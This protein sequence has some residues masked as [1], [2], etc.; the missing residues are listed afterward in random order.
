MQSA[1]VYPSPPPLVDDDSNEDD[2]TTNAN[3]ND[4][5]NNV[6]VN[7]SSSDEQKPKVGIPFTFNN[8][9]TIPTT[10]IASMLNSPFG[11]LPNNGGNQ[12][13]GA[14]GFARPPT[15]ESVSTRGGLG[16]FRPA[17]N[18]NNNGNHPPGLFG[19]CGNGNNGNNGN[20]GCGINILGKPPQQ[21]IPSN[22]N[23]KETIASLY[24]QLT[25][26]RSQIEQLTKSIDSMYV[27]ISKMV[28]I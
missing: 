15:T 20:T 4:N 22:N 9:G 21:F 10:N 11:R 12:P 23:D 25:T 17:D 27:I 7:N 1:S 26:M 19:V 2:V 28:K 18:T 8:S 5:N 14:F 24:S 3:N 13:I 6:N 16:C